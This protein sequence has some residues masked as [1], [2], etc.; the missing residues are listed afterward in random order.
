MASLIPMNS[1]MQLGVRNGYLSLPERFR[2]L[3]RLFSTVQLDVIW[4]LCLAPGA[5]RALSVALRGQG[6]SC[7]EV[8]DAI[9]KTQLDGRFERFKAEVA[10]QKRTLH[11]NVRCADGY[12]ESKTNCDR[13]ARELSAQAIKLE[14]AG[15]VLGRYR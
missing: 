8:V 3:I 11:M 12:P 13:A 2:T 10:E 4:K 14:T 6:V 5:E 9:A 7:S 15:M 1:G